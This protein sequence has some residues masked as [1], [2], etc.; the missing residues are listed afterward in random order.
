MSK[1]SVQTSAPPP[2][3]TA[4][5]EAPAR[6]RRRKSVPWR[7]LEALASL[8]LTVVLFVL[9]VILVFCGTLA[10]IDYGIWAVVK[11]YF[12]SFFVWMP[13]QLFFPRTWHIAHWIG[14]P[15]PGGWTI[16]ALLLINVLAAHVTRFKLTWKRSGI[17]L[18]HAGVIV[19]MLGELCTG[20]FAVE[21]NM[22]IPSGA[23][24]NYIEHMD[25]MELDVIDPTDAK[26][27]DVVTVIPAAMLHK[28]GLI[29]NELL[30]FDVKVERYMANSAEPAAPKPGE[31]NP[32]TAGF[33][34]KAV[35]APKEPGVGVDQDQKVDMPSAYV[36]LMKKGTDESLGTYFVSAYWD[37]MGREAQEVDVD[38]RKF[39]L[40][41]RP[42]R[43][44]KPY[45]VQLL[46]FTH[47]VYPGTE[48]PK[49]FS[50]RVRLLD[51]ANGEDR[52]VRIRMNEPLRYHGETFYQASFLPG[53]RGTV[54]QVVRNP[55]WLL[56]Y[57]AC[58]L[59][60][61]GMAFH[62]GLSLV[63]FLRKRAAQ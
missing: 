1:A 50:S 11:M 61:V 18:L 51:K 44:Y 20:L 13:L 8:K 63:G 52:E 37:M 32:A 41:L 56:P 45:T 23:S 48:I 33:G 17:I 54:L 47:S 40:D 36:T 28:G 15:F 3:V 19:L 14:A 42:R 43:E 31:D 30:P 60:A 2:P 38:A 59:V 5:Q 55:G 39:Q 10:Q 22:T 34:L 4:V 26:T 24:A 27:D 58:A 7:V 25:D 6:S 16:G 35:A 21:G 62:F 29:Q 57:I 9:S 46:E 12:R 49:D 53:D